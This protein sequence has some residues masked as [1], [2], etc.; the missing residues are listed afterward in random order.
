MTSPD[1]LLELLEKAQQDETGLPP[2]HLW[3]PEHVGEIDMRIARDGSWYY[4]G[5]PIQRHRLVKLFSTVL[6]RED[7][8]FFLI[9][10]VEK[11][12]I[13]VDD[14]PFV[15]TE[16][17]RVEEGGTSKLVFTTNVDS[18]VIASETHPLWVITDPQTGEPSPYLRVRDNLDALIGRSAFYQLVD[19]AV[20]RD[21]K[22]L[23][24]SDGQTFELGAL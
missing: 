18:H 17:Q 12:K 21:G 14:A 15:A 8:D 2:V 6:L 4:L 13:T 19:W 1:E 3:K 20:E 24:E 5:D 11:L 23:V 10:P 16:V 22:L 7:D 9:T